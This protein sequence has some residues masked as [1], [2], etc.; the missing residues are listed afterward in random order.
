MNI[1]GTREEILITGSSGFI[2]QSLVPYLKDQ[3]VIRTLS[4]RDYEEKKISLEKVKAVIHLTGIAHKMTEINPKIYFNINRDLTLKFAN[5]AKDSGV[6][7]FIF[8]SS[9]KVY[10]EDKKSF[11][12]YSQC[13]PDDPYGKSKLAA[14][15]GLQ[16]MNS[17][18][19]KVA[20]IRPPLVYGA[21]VKGN[22]LRLMNVISKYK[23]IPLGGITNNRSMVYVKNLAALIEHVIIHQT[24]GIMLAGDQQSHSTSDLANRIAKGLNSSSKIIRL[25]WLL[26]FLIKKLKPS[27]GKRLFESL[28][29]DNTETNQRIN[30]TPPFSFNEGIEEM[31][32]DYLLN[33]SE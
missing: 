7:Q 23:I 12:E 18:T 16:K 10:R 8:L 13:L 20:I 6:Q 25:P 24:T 2:G 30:F 27:V 9:T 11:N 14:E 22:L 29:F 4:L 5:L 26:K 1:R 32:K 3:Y 21:G 15:E 17:D 28:V 33:P 19:F 31:T